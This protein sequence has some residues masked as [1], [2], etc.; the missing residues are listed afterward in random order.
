MAPLVAAATAPR[1]PEIHGYVQTWWTIREELENGVR[2]AGSEDLAAQT[3]GGFSLRRA[4][5][6][7][8]DTLG[9]SRLRYKVEI[10]L[11]DN[12]R[13]TDCYLSARLVPGWELA[14]GQQKIPSTYESLQSS[15]SLDFA[16]RSQLSELI[17]DWSLSRTPYIS[18]YMGNRALLR[19]TGLSLRGRVGPVRG[20]AM[21]GNGLG[22]NLFIG[23]KERQG[24]L[25][26]NAVTDL[27]YGLRLD[28]DLRPGLTA[29]GHASWNRHDNSLFNDGKTVID[30]HRWSWSADLGWVL[31][32]GVALRGMYAAGA[33]D[34][35]YYRDDRTNYE[36]KG[37]ELKALVWL[38]PDRLQAGL[39]YDQ[40][41]DEYNQAGNLVVKR[42]WTAGINASPSP[43]SRLQLNYVWKDIDEPYVPDLSDDLLLL[44]TQF[45]F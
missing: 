5:L 41:E 11:E 14:V 37:Y 25:Y 26:G 22:A 13:L 12:A 6:S 21:V 16:A 24:F 43:G 10:L 29:G 2:Q 45:V 7:L 20:L 34:D 44:S 9:S 35:D 1:V 15:T 17:A 32:R 36:Y 31:P 23:G 38:V 33:V 8:A 3:T 40:Y 19:D 18:P 42:H 39:R 30:L 27:F 28:A 4:R